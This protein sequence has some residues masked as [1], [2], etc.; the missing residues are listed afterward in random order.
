MPAA[1]YTEITFTALKSQVAEALGD[2]GM[3]FYTDSDI[4]HYIYEALTVFQSMS[5]YWRET[6]QFQPGALTRWAVLSDTSTNLLNVS[7]QHALV[8]DITDRELLQ[9][10]LSDLI[11]TAPNT[12]GDWSG[13]WSLTDHFSKSEIVSALNRVYHRFFG[14]VGCYIRPVTLTL[15]PGKEYFQLPE[16]TFDVLSVALIDNV[17]NPS[18]PTRYPLFKTGR[19]DFDFYRGYGVLTPGTPN[20]WSLDS[21]TLLLRIFPPAI[22]T[23]QLEVMVYQFPSPDLDPSTSETA[24]QIPP[25]L[26]WILKYGLLADLLRH[27]GESADWP[28][29][30]YCEQR[31]QDGINLAKLQLPTIINA[32]VNDQQIIQSQ[33]L[34][35]ESNNQAWAQ[36]RGLPSRLIVASWDLL[37]PVPIRTSTTDIATIELLLAQQVRLPVGGDDIVQLPKDAVN[38]IVEYGKHCALLKTSGAEFGQSMEAYKKLV[39]YAMEYNQILLANSKTFGFNAEK[40]GD[41]RNREFKEKG[42]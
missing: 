1:V 41:S 31:W 34:D 32:R 27:D 26:W 13:A 23:G 9:H 37:S 42:E 22:D 16:N 38:A 8:S 11:E 19:E 3:V 35:E 28:R 7:S 30:E 10:V 12:P 17:T 29:A 18:S 20:A 15:S 24:L 21:D 33:F 39:E 6:A 2:S 14:E 25:N 36:E 40:G 4:T 5:N